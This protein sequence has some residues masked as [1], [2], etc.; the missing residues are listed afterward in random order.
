MKNMMKDIVIALLAVAA[1]IVAQTALSFAV[2]FQTAEVIGQT[3]M[4]ALF[5]YA[6]VRSGRKR[7]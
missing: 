7:R 2:G 4:A 6:V 3:A 5:L 1:V